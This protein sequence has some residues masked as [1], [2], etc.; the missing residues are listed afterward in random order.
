MPHVKYIDEYNI[1]AGDVMELNQLKLFQSAVVEHINCSDKLKNR[2]YEL[3]IYEG[4]VIMPV[5][6]SPFGEPKAYRA[7]D[8][9][10]ALRSSDC[11][12]ITVNQL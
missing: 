9:V 2:L 1:V 7:G 5:L 12:D 4:A 8:S 11:K 10:I 3:G 6:K